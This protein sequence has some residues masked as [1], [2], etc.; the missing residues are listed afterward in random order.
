MK[1]VVTTYYN[2]LRYIKV[3]LVGGIGGFLSQTPTSR[4]LKKFALAV[5]A[6]ILVL[7]GPASVLAQTSTPLSP[8]PTP[9][10]ADVL[11]SMPNLTSDDEEN[12]SSSPA[13]SDSESQQSAQLNS[14]SIIRLLNKKSFRG[15]EKVKVIVDNAENIT[16]DT[17]VE[18]S[19]GET[20]DLEVFTVNEG[21]RKTVTVK[22]PPHF[23]PGKY[24][25]QVT[26]SDGQSLEQDFTWGVLAINTNKSIYLS[27]EALAKEGLPRET[28]KIGIGVLD[29]GG[30]VVCDARVKLEIRPASPELQRG[31]NPK[32]EIT[33][34]STDDGTIIVNP[35]CF[36]FEVTVKPD[37]ETS[38]EVGGVGLYNI[39]L[40][41]ETKNGSYTITDSFEARDSV[42]FDVERITATRIFPPNSYPVDLHIT[43]NQD[44]TGTITEVV[45]GNFAV[46]SSGVSDY[47][48]IEQTS[49]VT[50]VEGVLG[51]SSVLGM[52]FEGP[53]PISQEFSEHLRD[54]LERDLY[55]RFN[56]AGHDGVDFSLPEGTPVTAVDD[57][58]IVLAGQGA[59]GITVVI[60][61]SWGRSY[62]GH[63]SIPKVRLGDEVK[64]RDVI[65]LSGN[66]GLS[67]GPHLHFSIKEA[68]PD[69][70]NGYYGKI[71]PLPFL[72]IPS[73]LDPAN[74][75]KLISWDVSL[76][77]GEKIILGY[78]YRAPNIS[79]EF[80]KIGALKFYENNLKTFEEARQWMIAADAD[81]SGTNTVSP[82]TGTTNAA[83]QTYT[84]T[85]TATETMDSG[86][87]TI[88]VPS[89]WTAPQSSTGTTTGYTT[90]V[91]NSN[92]TAARVIANADSLTGWTEDDSDMCNTVA[93]LTLDSTIKQEG[94]NSISC[95]NSSSALTDAGD[96]FGYD[97]T[98]E[99]WTE[100]TQIAAWV[101]SEDGTT[102]GDL[103]MAYDNQNTCASPIQEFNDPGL[104]AN[105]WTY[106]KGTM[107]A[108]RTSVTTFCFNAGTDGLDNDK[109]WVDDLLIGPLKVGNL[110]ITGSGPWDINVRILD[111]VNTET[112]TVTYGS[113]AV[114]PA[115]DITNPST[116]Q[117]YTFTTQ[118]RISDAGTL[119]NIA[120]HPTVDITAPAGPT[121]DQLL[122]HGA[123]F[124]GGVENAFTF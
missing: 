71:D 84:F 26:T 102:A 45:P 109:I 21:A 100:Y 54:P 114:D 110:S 68:S 70:Q 23:R 97:F 103:Q 5:F 20:V 104:V 29:E 32:S 111:A 55:A 116:A 81:G 101:R 51:T 93:D 15:N 115:G 74:Q 18:N 16:I 59:Y 37:Y 79:P 69:M 122:R 31:E 53:F 66:T 117:L 14:T 98:A 64:R 24:T 4:S 89:G 25:I 90:A 11:K 12:A 78:F 92:A 105:T 108:A 75:L 63:L 41:G 8:T 1:R 123:W 13:F 40:T 76:K 42:P 87:F 50:A 9:S 83:D 113:T 58:K 36:K 33:V 120:S 67:T 60:E 10:Q 48:F 34:L 112:F 35:E 49:S 44:F 43:A 30:Q 56:L 77:K 85:F 124:S 2:I 72:G 73:T 88:T 95:D 57:G 80:Y 38:Y 47:P 52:P 46:K 28:A 91:G 61:H 3:M 62:Y 86:G 119:T 22:P 6:L 27:A 96:S 118:S 82:T 7:D 106:M 19:D 65:A 107:T 94:T 121:L 99:N 17:T 39:T